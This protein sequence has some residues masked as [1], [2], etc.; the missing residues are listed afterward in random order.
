MITLGHQVIVVIFND[1]LYF[2]KYF[3]KYSLPFLLIHFK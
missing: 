3:A 2:T 1:L